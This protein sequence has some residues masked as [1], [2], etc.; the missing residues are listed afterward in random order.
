MSKKS[1][2][3]HFQ[4][5][6]LLGLVIVIISIFSIG[7]MYVFAENNSSIVMASPTYLIPTTKAIPSPTNYSPTATLIPTFIYNPTFTPIPSPTSFL[8]PPID[9]PTSIPQQSQ[10][11]PTAANPP[12]AKSS[13]NCSA[14]L[15]YAAAMHQY[16]LDSIDYIHQP[17]LDYYQSMIDQALGNRDALGVVQAQRGLAAEKAQVSAEKASENK[18]YKA[19]RAAINASCQ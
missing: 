10:S 1:S 7:I 15:D 2:L 5:L 13:S 17:M 8:L 18:R 11:N 19:E 3:S 9:R 6:V 12:P 4:L 14:Q 16:Y